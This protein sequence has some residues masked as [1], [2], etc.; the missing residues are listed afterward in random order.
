MAGGC[1][2]EEVYCNC[3]PV[4]NWEQR[5]YKYSDKPNTHLWVHGQLVPSVA[6]NVAQCICRWQDHR[7]VSKGWHKAQVYYFCCAF[8]L[9]INCTRMSRRIQETIL[10]HK[11][12]KE[13]E[14]GDGLKQPVTLSMA[15]LHGE[16]LMWL[17][18]FSVVGGGSNHCQI[19][20]MAAVNLALS[21]IEANTPC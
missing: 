2:I 7:A 6:R 16:L 9:C 1:A 15:H 17:A 12:E 3:P 21:P 4:W 11:E 19:Q 10:L 20:L 14:L 18:L 13:A 5:R 8:H